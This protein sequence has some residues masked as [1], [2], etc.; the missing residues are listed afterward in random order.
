MRP[1]RRGSKVLIGRTGGHAS[2]HCI[3]DY[4]FFYDKRPAA[5]DE[6]CLIVYDG[7]KME[8]DLFGCVGEE[9][10]CAGDVAG[11]LRNVAFSSLD[12]FQEKH[13]ITRLATM[14]R[15]CSTHVFYLQGEF[16][17]LR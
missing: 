7:K 1:T 4:S 8:V 12:V 2:I 6:E 11:T 13:V 9:M 10:L 14:G 16:R 15:I 3:G 5:S 17:K